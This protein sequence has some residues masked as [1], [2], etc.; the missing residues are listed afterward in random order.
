MMTYN[1]IMK[2]AY[3]TT[4]VRLIW[5]N[6]DTALKEEVKHLVDWC[7]TN[8]LVP[9]VG[10][11]KENIVDFRRSQPSHTTLLN[12]TTVE[13]VSSTKFQ[14]ADNR[15]SELVP[16][17]WSSCQESSAVHLPPVLDEESKSP[18]RILTIFY[19]CTIKSIL[20]S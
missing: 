13:R 3:D 8:N 6:S 9:N 16:S 12:D 17:H 4:V 20:T 11:T 14:G 10:K 2:F 1:H 7:K 5:N 15:H 18:P 19:K